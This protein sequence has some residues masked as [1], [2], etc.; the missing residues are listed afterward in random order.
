[1]DNAVY[2]VVAVLSWPLVYG[3]YRLRVTG[4]ENVPDDGGLVLAA[5]HTSNFDPW[6]LGLPLFPRRQLRFMAKIELFN[7]VLGPILWAGGAF[8]VRR[9]EGGRVRGG[10][11][12]RR[13]RRG[14]GGA[15]WADARRHL[16]PRPLPARERADDDPAAGSRRLRAHARRPRGGA[17]ALRRRAEPGSGLHRAPRRPVRPTPGRPGRGAEDSR[18]PAEE[19]RFA[20]AGARGRTVRRARG[21]VAPLPPNSDARR[22]RPPPS[23]QRSDPSVGG[24]VGPGAQLGHERARQAVGAA[25]SGLRSPPWTL[26]SRRRAT[27]SPAR[28]ASR[29]RRSSCRGRTSRRSWSLRGSPPTRAA[30][31]RTRRFSATSSGARRAKRT[32]LRSPR[33]SG[34]R[35]PEPSRHGPPAPDGRPS[36]VARAAGDPAR[37]VRVARDSART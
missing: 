23:R 31:G 34:N 30:S 7:P 21:G 36:R 1:M 33:P 16:R 37:L 17:G 12:P 13:G 24:G 29:R 10:R 2:Y 28:A 3:V 27:R 11:L 26:G 9:G 18:G 35:R 22:L 6:P 15:R 32:S 14:R 8:P 25:R 19:V 5:N 4:R 20:R